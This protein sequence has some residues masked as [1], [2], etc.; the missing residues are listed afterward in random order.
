MSVVV[1]G[2]AKDITVFKTVV[3][4]SRCVKA[5]GF[6]QSVVPLYIYWSIKAVDGKSV[7]G[8][9]G[10]KNAFGKDKTKRKG[11]TSIVVRTPT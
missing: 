9:C 5:G 11:D 2:V 1:L 10:K 8:V 3:I 6:V 7:G 4:V